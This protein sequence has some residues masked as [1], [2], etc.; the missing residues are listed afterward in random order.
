MHFQHVS[1][2]R[3]FTG[4]C[5]L[6]L[7][8]VA[9]AAEN[10]TQSWSEASWLQIQPS[11]DLKWIDCYTGL[12]CAR[13]Q[14]PLN[15]SDPGG[16]TAAIALTR[17]PA[18]VSSADSTEY[19][20][21][22]LFNP[23]G[24]GG[25]GVD[26][27][28]ELGAKLQVILGPRFDLVGFDPRGIHRSTPAISFYEST[29]ER[30]MWNFTPEIELN[31]S[32]TM[33]IAAFVAR[34]QITGS[35]AAQRDK[36]VLAHMNTD[37][38]ARDMLSINA[39]YG[40]DK[41]QY[42]G[43]SYGSILGATFAAMFPD[44]IH[45]LAIDGVMDSDADYYNMRWLGN[46]LDTDKTLH[47]FFKACLEEGPEACP[48]HEPSIEAM[49]NKLN[50]IYA[51]LIKSPI[52]V[53]TSK[54]YGLADYPAL[55]TVLYNLFYAPA[56]WPAMAQGLQ[57]LSKGNA[58]ILYSIFD[59]PR[60]KCSC[61]TTPFPPAPEA[62]VALTCNDGEVVPSGLEEAERHYNEAVSNFGSWASLFAGFR[63]SCGGWPRS[64]PKNQFRGPVTAQNTSVPLLI[65]GNTADPATPIE[66]ARNVT[67][68][69]PGSVLLTQ[70]SPGHASI[71]APSTCTAMHVREY[72][73]NGTLPPEGTVC[74]MDGFIF[75]KAP[76]S[77][78]G[79]T[80][81]EAAEIL[82]ALKS[83]ASS[84]VDRRRLPPLHV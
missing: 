79:E 60:F 59:Q 21:P 8:S 36:N 6:A 57:D 65:I 39:A 19:L 29:E 4:V 32:D 63:N 49:E 61:D 15:Y 72:F 81:R 10:D 52:P 44:K 9:F 84:R 30:L 73:V 47:W 33:S 17:L 56:A 71:N 78:R 69:F 55:R 14:V 45:R 41:I 40:R 22:I 25:S 3:F 74:P 54:S 23:G 82:E 75:K 27:I 68:K 66:G 37:H 64:L 77:K 83:I 1:K 58:T 53:Q 2:Q 50:A 28:V 24:P 70:D 12:Q 67:S 43:F 7:T 38:T 48:F 11:K 5:L 76:A 20:G 35:L 31:R 62:L 34:A 18:N 26:L 80:S 42:W 13:L 51:S 16:E 46:V